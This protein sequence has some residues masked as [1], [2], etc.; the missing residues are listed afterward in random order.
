MIIRECHEPLVELKKVC[1]SVVVRID[2]GHRAFVRKTVALMLKKAL[3]SLPIGMTFVIRDA[4]RSRETQERIM[5]E[6]VVRFMTQNPDWTKARA[7]KEA[8]KYVADTKGLY[9][10]GHMTG[11]ALDLRLLKEGR[12]VSMRSRKLSYAENADPENPKL[13]KYLLNNRRLMSKAL[14]SAGFTQCHNEFW[15]WS[16][17]D[18][19]WA[20]R[21]GRKTAMYGVIDRG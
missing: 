8:R 18:V 7:E 3:A 4:W 11:A 17:G 21:T 12:R 5:E 19:H 10:S 1:P 13:P 9:S 2:G 20:G 15:H 16:Y 6:F 14:A